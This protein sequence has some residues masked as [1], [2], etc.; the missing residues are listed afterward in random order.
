MRETNRL[1]VVLRQY[2]DRPSFTADRL[3]KLSGLPKPTIV[4]WLDG[5]VRKPRQWQDLIKAAIALDLDEADATALLQSAGYPSIE[6]LLTRGGSEK[7]QALLE[8]WAEAARLRKQAQAQAKSL[9]SI[10]PA[11]MAAAKHQLA[12]L[13]LETLPSPAPLPAGS[14]MPLRRNPLFVGRER[15]LLMLA[16]AL[17][18]GATPVISQAETAA[19][20]GLGGIGKTQLA[21]ELVH[22]YGQYFAGGVFWLSFADAESVPAEVA[23]CG[24]PGYLDLRPNFDALS[25][26]EQVELVLAAWRSPLPR[27]LVFDNCEEEPLLARWRPTTGGCFVLVTSRRAV[28]DPALGVNTLSLDVLDR[29]SSVELLRKHASVAEIESSALVAIAE[30]LGDLPLALHLAGTYLSRYRQVLASLD[31]LAQLQNND[32]LQHPSLQSQGITISP[33]EHVQHVG[34]TFALS[35]NR[36]DHTDAT[37]HI[38][39]KVLIRATFLAPGE[40]IPRSLLFSASARGSVAGDDLIR[41]DAVSRLVSLGLIDTAID[42][43][44]RMHRLVAMF[45]RA[46]IDDADAR[47]DVEQTLI[48]VAGAF[49]GANDIVSMRALQPHLKY[50]TDAALDRSDYRAAQLCRELGYYLWRTNDW[51]KAHRYLVS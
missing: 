37:D 49:N 21:V 45:V 6:E 23:V 28:W 11:A 4:N 32:L 47:T 46:H 29:A 12:A 14:R 5:W 26:Q 38:A 42:G 51:T 25:L 7:D 9:W 17:R 18:G 41:A 35:L 24:G 27:L 36:L 39:R 16:R 13:P 44:L 15:D 10:G 31:Y 3:A 20:T 33:T 43:S 8:P 2:L 19:A 34:R 1:A 30:E 22:R 48:D 40:L 50:V